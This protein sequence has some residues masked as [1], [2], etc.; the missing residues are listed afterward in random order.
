M[1]ATLSAL[2]GF[3][4][5]LVLL[6]LGL[7]VY[8]VGLVFSGRKAANTFTPSG[9]DLPGFGE[10]LTRA[11]DNCFETL[12]VF[13]AIAFVASVAGQLAVTDPLAPWVL[14]ARLAQSVTHIVSTSVPAVMLRATLFFVQMLIYAWWTLRLLG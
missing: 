11:R 1:S 10:R 7:G 3:A 8:R 13:G 4:G 12:P 9:S 14:T 2:L 5:W 6:S